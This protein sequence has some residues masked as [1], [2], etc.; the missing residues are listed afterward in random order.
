MVL[1]SFYITFKVFIFEAFL[2]LVD[3]LLLLDLAAFMVG[4]LLD[5][6]LINI[7]EADL[8]I[9][10]EVRDIFMNLKV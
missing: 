8:V 9:N 3:L 10:F 6:D 5:L 1:N 7:L 4:V 2:A